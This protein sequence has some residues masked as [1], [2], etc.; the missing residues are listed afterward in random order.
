MDMDII[1]NSV[2]MATG[3]VLALAIALIIISEVRL[4]TIAYTFII[5]LIYFL[6]MLTFFEPIGA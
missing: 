5:S 4:K 1:F 3:V 6:I 2:M